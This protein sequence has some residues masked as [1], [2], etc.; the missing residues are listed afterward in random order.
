MLYIDVGGTDVWSSACAARARTWRGMGPS[1]SELG[2]ARCGV[3]R[4]GRGAGRSKKE[5]WRGDEQG[6]GQ[7]ARE[8]RA[9]RTCGKEKLRRAA[10]SRGDGAGRAIR[11]SE[12][13]EEER[14]R[15]TRGRDGARTPSAGP[16]GDESTRASRGREARQRRKRLAAR[17]V[18][19]LP[20]PG[21]G[22]RVGSG[23]ESGRA[24]EG[25]GFPLVAPRRAG[26]RGRA[27][28]RGSMGVFAKV[29]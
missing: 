22:G 5:R 6:E 21:T 11:R 12:R 15:P 9:E 16:R 25:A 27:R 24:A 28:R 3:K 8:R 17:C 19:R 26:G 10:A 1:D 20:R 2:R 13:G 18:F 14:G 23:A 4:K 7:K 29:M